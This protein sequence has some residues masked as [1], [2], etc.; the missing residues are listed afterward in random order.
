MAARASASCVVFAPR[1]GLR[2]RRGASSYLGGQ[3]AVGGTINYVSRI[4]N[5]EQ[6][7]FEAF[8][9]IG[10]FLNRRTAIGYYGQ[11]NNTPNWTRLDASYLGSDGY[12][13]R[14]PHNAGDFS[15]SW[16]SDINSQVSNT[17][18]A[19]FHTEERDGHWGAPLLNPVFG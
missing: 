17:M 11:I 18:A 19:E 15:L 14:T 1:R 8:G 2:R 5:R 10:M 6:R 7:G 12:V 3:G 9:L 16:L 13:E 4:A